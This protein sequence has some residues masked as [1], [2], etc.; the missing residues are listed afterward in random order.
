MSQLYA[1]ITQRNIDI[2]STERQSRYEF[3]NFFVHSIKKNQKV[4]GLFEYQPLGFRIHFP[5]KLSV[6]LV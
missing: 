5:M 2:Y 3:L 6:A 1:R 4:L